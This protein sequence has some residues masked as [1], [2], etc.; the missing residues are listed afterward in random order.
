[1]IK[2][3]PPIIITNIISEYLK[4]CLDTPLIISNLYCNVNVNN[5]QTKSIG[6]VVGTNLC[7]RL[8]FLKVNFNLVFY[9]YIQML[10][11][12]KKKL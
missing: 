2:N 4:K 10:L 8:I 6:K 1:M 3:V 11:D 12:T 7:Y 5:K 9:I